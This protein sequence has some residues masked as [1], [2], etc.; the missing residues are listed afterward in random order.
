MR[1]RGILLGIVL[2]ITSGC[3]G[4]QA[5]MADLPPQAQALREVVAEMKADA[6]MSCPVP[7]TSDPAALSSSGELVALA[8][9]KVGSFTP[10]DEAPVMDVAP[11]WFQ[12]PGLAAVEECAHCKAV[13][14]VRISS[15]YG[16][17]RDPKRRH[18]Y[19]H[20][21]GVDIRAPKGSPVM[22]FKGGTVIRADRFSSYGLT[23]EVRQYDGL[24]AR[25]AHLNEIYVKKGDEVDSG[26]YV[27]EVGRTGR[28][29]GSHLHFELLRDGKSLNPMKFLTKAE[30]VVRCLELESASR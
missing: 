30:Q 15:E 16:K 22:A 28:A 10:Q 19:R 6:V 17:R 5:R 24:V 18:V 7:D 14:A 20:H 3:A 21:N 9:L 2:L 1:L 4:N 27:G 13:G 12:E 8:S 26:F 11:V 29:T 23:V 25:Y